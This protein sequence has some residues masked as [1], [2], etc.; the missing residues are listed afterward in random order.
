VIE[1]T[2]DGGPPRHTHSR[3][4]ES[5]YVL[6]AGGVLHADTAFVQE[7]F[8]LAGALQVVP[9]GPL[10]AVAGAEVALERAEQAAWLVAVHGRI[11]E[12]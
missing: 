8:G 3:E 5:F 4:D 11:V 10:G 7:R 6:T 2:I 12:Q 1:A 9:D